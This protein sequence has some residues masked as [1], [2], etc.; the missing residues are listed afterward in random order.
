[1]MPSSRPDLSRNFNLDVL[2]GV[3]ILLVVCHHLGIPGF[4]LG[5]WIGVDLFFVLSGFLISGL[6]FREWK[7]QGTVNLARFYIR[8]GLK[9]YPAFYAL[10]AATLVVNAVLPGVPS[11]PVTIHS[12]L[13]EAIFVQNYFPG[14]W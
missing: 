9:I 2:R 14:I 6:L 7:T 8:R 10:L 1:M 12:V 5:G 11:Q 4:R 13:A 3:A